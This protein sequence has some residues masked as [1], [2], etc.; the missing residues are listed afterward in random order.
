ML[1]PNHKI[2]KGNG[3]DLPLMTVYLVGKIA[4]NCMDKCLAWRKQ[5]IDHYRKYKPV[6]K[7]VYS[8]AYDEIGS[9]EILDFE[10]YPISF[11]C[12]LNSGESKTADDLGLKSHLS[13]NL[14]YDKDFIGLKKGYVIVANLEDF[15]E[16]GI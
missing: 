3:V 4:G 15:M 9:N 10:S 14:I 5:I 1:N 13:K 12:P 7:T 6:Y 2:V 11:L 16:N 8:G